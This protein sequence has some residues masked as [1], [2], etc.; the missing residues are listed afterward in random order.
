MQNEPYSPLT[1]Q[2]N[3]NFEILNQ[4]RLRKKQDVR[5]TGFAISFFQIYLI[6]SIDKVT[7]EKLWNFFVGFFFV[8]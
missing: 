7:Y 2:K 5:N 8:S 4:M 1:F 6:D 3:S